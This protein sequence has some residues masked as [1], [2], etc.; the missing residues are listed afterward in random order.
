MKVWRLSSLFHFR[1]TYVAM[2]LVL[3][4]L[5]LLSRAQDMT[6]KRIELEDSKVFFYYDLADTARGRYYTVNLYSSRDNYLNPL[7]K[8]KGDY[9]LEVLPGSDRV[10]TLDAKE[11][12]GETFNGK[13]GFELRAKVFIPFIRIEGFNDY[14]KFKRGKP[15]EIQW[16]GGRPQNVLNFE[17]YKGEEKIT[18]FSNIANA[19]KYNLLFA[20]DTKPGSDYHFRIS[21]S[22]NKD[23]VVNTKEFAISRKVPLVLKAV[24]VVLVGGALFV[25]LKPKEECA[26]CLPDFPT[27][28][29]N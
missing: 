22:K 27:N 24:P 20:Q 21:D 13:L 9:G 8:L 3:S 25:L 7:Q 12:F 15:Y 10:I 1:P 23:E 4:C 16:S 6:I 26:G 14:K 19:G 18:V 28:P 17:L 5:S 11:E 29:E 2:V